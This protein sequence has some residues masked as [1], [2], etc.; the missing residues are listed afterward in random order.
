[1]HSLVACSQG[2]IGHAIESEVRLAQDPMDPV[3]QGIPTNCLLTHVAVDPDDYAFDDPQ[4][5]VG[6]Y[7]TDEEKHS[8]PG[9]IRDAGVDGFRSNHTAL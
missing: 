6:P 3:S 8:Q 9:I 7:L 1:M 4:K 2:S 5:F